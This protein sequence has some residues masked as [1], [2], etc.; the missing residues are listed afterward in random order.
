MFSLIKTN[1]NFYCVSFY[2]GDVSWVPKLSQG[3]YHIYSKD[4]IHDAAI[5]RNK[6]TKVENV[7]YNIYPYMKFII[8]HYDSLPEAV[9]F[10]KNN[11]FPRH[12]DRVTFEQLSSRRVFTAIESPTRWKLKYPVSILS[13][14]NGFMELNTS[15]YTRHHSKKY[16]SSLHGFYRFIFKEKMDPMYMRFAPGANY[17]VPRENI[18]LRSKN[19][20]S[21]L[22]RFVEH[23]Q[24]SAES[25]MIE[26]AL[27]SIWSA[28]L[29]ESYEMS[30]PISDAKLKELESQTKQKS[31]L[32]FLPYLLKQ[33]RKHGYIFT[34]YYW[35]KFW[36]NRWGE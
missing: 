6:T 9:V 20:Y 33:I 24:H 34:I 12:V 25:H 36:G 15:W 2:E 28:P 13:C 30:V 22:K 4:E 18:L 19:F 26:R 8:D 27:F 7:G 10:C 5:D 11:V 17:V 32:I 3:A 1:P 29:E 16:F 31:K 23:D 21:N 35:N 14:D